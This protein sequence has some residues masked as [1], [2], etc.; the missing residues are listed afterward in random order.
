NLRFGNVENVRPNVILM[1]DTSQSMGAPD[2]K[3]PAARMEKEAAGAGVTQ[4]QTREMTRLERANAM[5]NHANLLK[6]LSKR[7]T[8][9][10]YSFASVPRVVPLPT[11]TQKRDAWRFNL[12]PDA[13]AGDSTQIGT[14]LRRPLEDLAGQPVAGALIVSDGGSNL[15]EDPLLV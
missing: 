11:D 6:E 3:L 12:P 5:L 14:A 4:G 2:A 7:Y 15:G 8:V 13:Q 1:V 10:L 9:R